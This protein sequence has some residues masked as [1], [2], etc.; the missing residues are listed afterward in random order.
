MADK[1]VREAALD[2]LLKIEEQ[3][4]YSNLLLN[5][6]LNEYKLDARDAGLLTEIVYGTIQ[7]KYTLDYY[8]GP[9][10]KNPRK[11]DKWVLILLRLSLYQ[12]QYLDRVPERAVI[13]QAVE[14]A[15]KR[16]HRGISGMVNGVLR[17]IQRKGVPALEE[18]SGP[19]KR[20]ATATS[21]PEWLVS[22]WVE[23]YGF[24]TT[25]QMCQTN[26]EAPP[27]T[28]RVNVDRATRD[29]V[30]AIMKE[31]GIEAEAG[32]LS[33]DAIRI[34]KGNAAATS[35]FKNGLISIQDE[36]SMLVARAL[37]PRPDEAVLDSCAAPGG[38]STHIAERMH[39]T[40][41]VVSLD[42]H[43]HKVKLIQDQ[44]E[45]LGLS[46][47]EAKALDSRK[48]GEAFHK[49]SFDRVLV[50]APCSGLGV[51][52]RKPDIK[53]SKQE[54]DIKRLADIQLDILEAAAP[55]VKQGGTIIYSTCTVDEEENGELVRTFLGR[56]EQFEFDESLIDRMPEKVK[57]RF[58]DARG[59]IQL[60]PQHFGSD[61]FYIAALRK[62]VLPT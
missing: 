6:K 45:R 60:M 24:E 7:R 50:D 25:E 30:I 20:L 51:V 1:N 13:H 29:E 37:D 56:N 57:E 32:E 27:V 22:R 55:L 14:I 43:E 21:H 9:F 46:N 47:I 28:A 19:V 36:S 34:L 18:I 39:N 62:K 11:L 52:R 3:Q 53:Y 10:L 26:L 54:K 44:S 49:E 2:I 33:D 12:M 42:L 41:K 5:R 40:G 58:P 48:A 35:A 4:S 16:G 31:E 59:E 8:L 15:K 38:K 61:G 23:R 17:N